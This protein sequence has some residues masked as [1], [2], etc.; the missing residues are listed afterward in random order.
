MNRYALTRLGWGIFTAFFSSCYLGVRKPVARIYEIALDVMHVEPATSLFVDDREENVQGARALGIH[1]LHV[2]DPS[3]LS[4]Q[5]LRA[6]I[7]VA[8]LR[9]SNHGPIFRNQ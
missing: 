5:L 8:G 2:T 3:G 9:G 7:E 4:D 6:G 1:A